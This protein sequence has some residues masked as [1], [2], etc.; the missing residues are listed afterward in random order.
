MH[1]IC[2]YGKEPFLRVL[3]DAGAT[4]QVSDDHGRTLLHEACWSSSS[5]DIGRLLLEQ[6]PHLLYVADAQGYVPLQY[7]PRKHWPH[8][9][10]FL[11]RE[12]D[13][14]W[15]KGRSRPTIQKH[16]YTLPVDLAFLVASGRMAPDQARSDGTESESSD[17]AQLNGSLAIGRLTDE[18]LNF[19]QKS[20]DFS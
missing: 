9:Q 5:W 7:V 12:W 8:W 19:I 18:S 17:S 2:R 16:H 10:A 6:D 14:F 4:V 13:H 11:K 15:P 3:L 20:K 1:M